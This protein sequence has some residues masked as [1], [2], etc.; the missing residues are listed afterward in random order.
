M[1]HAS[2]M[3]TIATRLLLT[4]EHRQRLE[5]AVRSRRIDPA[6]FVS[7]MIAGTTPLPVDQQANSHRSVLVPIRIYLTSEQRDAFRAFAISHETDI[8]VLISEHVARYLADIPDPP[9]PPNPSDRSTELRA[10]RRELAR[11]QSRRM[12]LGS[13][14]PIWLDQYIA[15]LEDYVNG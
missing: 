5:Y 1:E 2:G 9:S 3:F 11:I 8:G 13:T 14:T 10:Y 7:A 15:D 4:P 6:D 12:A